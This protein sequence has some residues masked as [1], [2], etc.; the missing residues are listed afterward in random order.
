MYFLFTVSHLPALGQLPP[1]NLAGLPPLS[2]NPQFSAFPLAPLSGDL[3]PSLLDHI[4]APLTENFT[5]TG[6][7]LGIADL[8]PTEKVTVSSTEATVTESS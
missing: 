2:I 7:E 3:A 5:S 8:P 6:E 4:S 1:L